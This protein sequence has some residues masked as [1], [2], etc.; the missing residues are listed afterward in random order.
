MVTPDDECTERGLPYCT[1]SHVFSEDS[2]MRR[3]HL[4][5]DGITVV[6]RMTAV[7]QLTGVVLKLGRRHYISNRLTESESATWP[8]SDLKLYWKRALIN[9]WN[10]EVLW[11]T[12]N[13]PSPDIQVTHNEIPEPDT[14]SAAGV[15]G[16]PSGSYASRVQCMDTTAEE[17]QDAVMWI[18]A[19]VDGMPSESYASGVQ[20]MDTT[21]EDL[22]IDDTTMVSIFDSTVDWTEPETLLQSLP[23]L[24]RVFDSPPEGFSEFREASLWPTL[25]DVLQIL[26]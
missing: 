5:P 16:S 25:E 4:Y 14:V 7:G 10:P 6:C 19:D 15:E 12:S 3:V 17:V 13:E 21:A 9:I 23:W 24:D 1:G 2:G 26:D 18:S 11:I 20:Y 8:E 22:Q